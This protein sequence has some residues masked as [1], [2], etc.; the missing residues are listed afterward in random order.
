MERNEG[1]MRRPYKASC[2]CN[3]SEWR[4][5]DEWKIKERNVKN[6]APMIGVRGC[7]LL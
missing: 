2:I 1:E 4:Q 6:K 3:S 5:S 7:E